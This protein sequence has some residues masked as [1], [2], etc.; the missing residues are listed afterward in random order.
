MGH[1]LE[2]K[3]K[4]LISLSI[5]KKRFSEKVFLLRLFLK[6]SH[7]LDIPSISRMMCEVIESCNIIISQRSPF[8]GFLGFAVWPKNVCTMWLYMLSLSR[9]TVKWIAIIFSREITK[10][11][12]K[13]MKKNLK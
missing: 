11:K 3:Y 1:L 8:G 13:Q 2:A 4:G 10:R 7:F 5:T 6:S 12:V 9:E